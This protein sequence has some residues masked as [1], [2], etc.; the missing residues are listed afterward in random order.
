MDEEIPSGSGLSA[1]ATV[2]AAPVSISPRPSP[3][4]RSAPQPHRGDLTRLKDIFIPPS[5]PA[6]LMPRT[7]GRQN[8]VTLFGLTILKPSRVPQPH[9]QQPNV[10]GSAAYTSQITPDAA[11]DKQSTPTS[12]SREIGR[13]PRKNKVEDDG[14]I[15]NASIATASGAV[16]KRAAARKAGGKVRSLGKAMEA[17]AE[18]REN[19]PKP[20]NPF[21]L[22]LDD[23]NTSQVAA[24][25]AAHKNPHRQSSG[26]KRKRQED[27]EVTTPAESPSK[28]RTRTNVEEEPEST[29]STFRPEPSSTPLDVEQARVEQLQLLTQEVKRLNGELLSTQRQVA[30][31][32]NRN[33]R[34]G[35]LDQFRRVRATD[36]TDPVEDHHLPPLTS[37]AS[38]C[39]LSAEEL[40][41]YCE[42]YSIHGE[43]SFD[44]DE[45][46]LG[47]AQSQWAR[48]GRALGLEPT[49]VYMLMHRDAKSA[50]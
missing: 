13:I 6:P 37:T 1:P 10:D 27:P 45:S 21:A 15:Q 3:A 34:D 24:S 49:I 23:P 43:R 14:H 32:Y 7:V 29:P 41:K 48:I 16:P 9:V 20:D 35:A 40:E 28:K 46:R 38:I 30:Q 5:P 22:E 26:A 47:K 25:P 42:L 44:S 17:M 31:L 4:P 2:S 39:A 11:A 50:S 12:K 36:W 19:H 8:A 33:C 18:Q